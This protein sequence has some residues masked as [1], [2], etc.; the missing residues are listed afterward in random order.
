MKRLCAI[1]T[2]ALTTGCV[3]TNIS[4]I[5]APLPTPQDELDV[6]LE[7]GAWMVQ[8]DSDTWAVPRG[9]LSL[10]YGLN[11]RI[12]LGVR[13]G[14]GGIG[15]GSRILL[16]SPEG[17]AATLSLGPSVAMGQLGIK[18]YQTN[19]ILP[20][21]MGVNLGQH[22]L[23][24]A[25]HLQT[26]I[27]FETGPEEAKGAL[28]MVGPGGSL[29]MAL[30]MGPRFRLMPEVAAWRPSSIN[31]GVGVGGSFSSEAAE[32]GG[33]VQGTVSLQWRPELLPPEER[34]QAR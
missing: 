5:Q 1:L 3:A 23:Y 21:L 14:S 8:V 16:T 30:Q 25:P 34:N 20:L 18:S 24:V 6:A 28:A 22:E 19:V 29:G 31:E 10:R 13:A 15:L 12:D 17:S 9:N 32:L 33:V 26:W 2:I 4:A 27:F 11:Q 7:G